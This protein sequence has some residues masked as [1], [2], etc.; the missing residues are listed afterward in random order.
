MSNKFNLNRGIRLVVDEY[1]EKTGYNLGDIAERSGMGMKALSKR[2]TDHPQHSRE[3]K[4]EDAVKILLACDYRLSE[5]HRIISEVK[6]ADALKN[7]PESDKKTVINKIVGNNNVNV[8]GDVT[9][10]LNITKH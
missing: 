9:G 5:A 4:D 2:L 1:I 10:D 8:G 3:L 7:L 6:V